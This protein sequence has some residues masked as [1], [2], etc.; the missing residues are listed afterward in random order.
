MTVSEPVS[1]DAR[2]QQLRRAV[3]NLVNNARKYAQDPSI[4]LWTTPDHLLSRIDDAG[5]GIPEDQ[6]DMA[7]RAFHRLDLARNQDKT[8][9][10]LG[11]A[12]ARDITRSHGGDL[13]LEDSPLGGLRARLRIP[14]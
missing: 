14:A 7:F 5:P 10:G 4:A 9:S 12:I 6:R 2:P 8:G 13:Y 11:L 3:I 1:I